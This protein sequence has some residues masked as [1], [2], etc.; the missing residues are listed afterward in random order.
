M[1]LRIGWL[2]GDIMNIYGDIGNL[3]ALCR[4]CIWRGIDA[5]WEVVSL[6][7]RLVPERYDLYLWGGGQ[8]AQQEL[9]SKDLVSTKLEPLREAV[10]SGA[11]VL[12]ICG[13]YQLLGH[14]YQPA[15]GPRLPGAG[16]LD[17]WTVAGTRRYIGNVVV[18][19]PWGE[20]VGFENHSGLTYLG[21]RAK[22][23]GRVRKGAGN[24]GS[25]GTEGAIQGTIFGT[26][27]HGP[28][29]PKN[30]KLADYLIAL[31]LQRR[32]GSIDLEPLDDT[33]ETTAYLSARARALGI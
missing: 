2:Y 10:Q 26:Y 18:E 33:L 9:A 22:P 23:L 5:F 1:E 25:D 21:Q 8:D 28:L 11:V 31:A 15:L 16:L 7:D 20:L 6:D 3:V 27:L 29:L 4:R 32:Y 13:G 12:A 17:V 14:Y 24:N 30:P 19:S